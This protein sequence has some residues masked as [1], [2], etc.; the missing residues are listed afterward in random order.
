LKDFQASKYRAALY[1][2]PPALQ[3]KIFDF[4]FFLG[5]HFCFWIRIHD[6]AICVLF[7]LQGIGSVLYHICPSNNSLPVDTFFMKLLMAWTGVICY[8]IHHD[9]SFPIIF[10]AAFRLILPQVFE[11]GAKYILFLGR[12]KL[13]KIM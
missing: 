3:I 13:R 10:L 4:I 9:L 12:K 7:F 11:V 2:D 5:G 8:E 1:R 6:I